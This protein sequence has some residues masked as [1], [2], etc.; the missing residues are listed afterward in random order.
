MAKNNFSKEIDYCLIDLV[1]S[2]P[3]LWDCTNE[4]YRRTD[5]K[6]AAWDEI[7]KQLGSNFTGMS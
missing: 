5:L 6:F 1:E 7:T 2:K 3:V 4:I